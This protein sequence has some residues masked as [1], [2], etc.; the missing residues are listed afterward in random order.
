MTS[1][2]PPFWIRHLRFHYSF[3]IKK[4]NLTNTCLSNVQIGKFPQFDEEITE[5]YKKKLN[6]GQSDLHVTC[7]CYGNIKNHDHTIDKISAEDERT[8]TERFR[9]FEQIVFSK[10]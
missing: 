9:P 10:L 6:L 7:G 2:D 1:F 3:F 5:L 4:S 8:A